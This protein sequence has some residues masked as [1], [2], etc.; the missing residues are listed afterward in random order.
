MS[1]K[2]IEH[3]IETFR[4]LTLS[5]DETSITILPE[6]GADII[7]LRDIKTD[8]EF[9]WESPQ[10]LRRDTP[11]KTFIDN[12]EGGWQECFPTGGPGVNYRGAQI[13][14]HGE[15]HALAWRVVD[16][17][18]GENEV[19]VTLEVQTIKTPFT[20][21]K[22]ITLRNHVNVVEIEEWITNNSRET[23]PILW[24]QH[25]AL[26]GNFLDK[27]CKI[28]AIAKRVF[29]YTLPEN[30]ETGQFNQNV[31]GEWPFLINKDGES[32]DVSDVPGP[33]AKTADMLFID[34][35]REGWISVTNR[36]RKVGLAF[37]FDP[38]V[39]KTVWFWQMYGGG[40][41]YPWYSRAYTMALEPFTGIPDPHAA[42]IDHVAGTRTI[43]GGE[44][45]HNRLRVLLYR[46]IKGVGRI[47][48]DG[49]I[50]PR[51]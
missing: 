47:S 38:E 36:E 51:I 4:A 20:L 21:R 49:V 40:T 9:L 37:L 32:V 17:A 46:G 30:A 18:E 45:L 12:Y 3:K 19:S 14:Q 41:G 43:R 39:Y 6:K 50:V 26:G 16:S 42:D 8:T 35:F 13:G 2:I 10:G 25:P 1:C 44:T 15:V 23:L 33:E 24:G 48:A 31:E 5:N 7:S 22:K 34:G 29:S 27:N 11:S 28:D